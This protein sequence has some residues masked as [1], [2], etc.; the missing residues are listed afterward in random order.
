[1]Q[2]IIHIDADCFFAAVEMRDR[3]ALKNNPIAVGGDPGRRG[4]ICTCN[5]HARRYGVKSAMA[6]AHAKRLC[7]HLLILP[8]DMAKY[9]VVS[10]Q[11]RDIFS[12]YTPVIE[13]LSLDEAFLDVSNSDCAAGS[14]TL[15][16]QEIRQRIERELGINVSAG[17]S[18]LKFLAKIASDWQKPNG[19]TVIPPGEEQPFLRRLSVSKL[20][21]VGP[22][23]QNKLAG[24]GITLCEDVLN[25]GLNSMVF[26]FG[27]IGERIFK[28]SKGIEF[29]VVAKHSA[30]KSV[31]VES[32][33]DHDLS[34]ADDIKQRLPQLISRLRARLPD[35]RSFSSQFVKIKF[36]NFTQKT[37][38]SR[39]GASSKHFSDE[40]FLRL[41]LAAWHSQKLP[42]RLLGVGVK[43]S[44]AH[45]FGQ[46]E[47]PFDSVKS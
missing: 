32:T 47:L 28:M 33:F 39:I 17:A 27:A 14:A 3:P 5:Y 44:S 6:S 41:M 9:R 34:S 21:G 30:K 35:S 15:I 29:G 45:Q 38:E 43:M 42:A 23:M 24:A 10:E 2:K 36:S 19:L 4:V 25:I 8:P 16:A 7:P 31:S 18:Q 20:P 26:R 1:M 12:E 13:P 11:M 22:V 40:G 46:L 37:M